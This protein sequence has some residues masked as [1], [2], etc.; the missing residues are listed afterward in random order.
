MYVLRCPNF[1]EF[2]S[3]TGLLLV[4][5]WTI[6]KL[7]PHGQQVL[8][9]A[10]SQKLRP[11]QQVGQLSTSAVYNSMVNT[12]DDCCH[13]ETTFHGCKQ[14]TQHLRKRF[15]N[16]DVS[17]VYLEESIRTGI[18]AASDWTQARPRDSTCMC[19]SNA[20]WIF[21]ILCWMIG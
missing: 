1:S 18:S 4:S 15:P 14:H 2:Y 3:K 20:L 8:Q 19:Q 16:L 12:H 17:C 6:G 7:W 10:T 13:E 21:C 11:L 9:G 5:T